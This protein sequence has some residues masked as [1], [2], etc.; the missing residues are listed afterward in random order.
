MEGRCFSE[1]LI[2]LWTRSPLSRGY[3]RRVRAS[4]SSSYLPPVP[5]I[6]PRRPRGREPANSA[7]QFSPPLSTT[8]F[9]AMHERLGRFPSINPLSVPIRLRMYLHV[10]VDL[11]LYGYPKP[12]YD[13]ETAS[14]IVPT[15]CPSSL[16]VVLRPQWRTALS[17]K[18]LIRQVLL[19]RLRRTSKHRGKNPLA[20]TLISSFLPG[21]SRMQLPVTSG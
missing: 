15:H 8:V 6:R 17:T 12:P 19:I 1:S 11:K 3:E 5:S 16:A 14:A 21:S 20:L 7:H 18:L 4:V 13:M 10:H 9:A 2:I